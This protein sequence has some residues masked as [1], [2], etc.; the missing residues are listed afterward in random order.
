MTN[1][2][3]TGKAI[4]D[5]AKA[6]TEAGEMHAK[7]I[8]TMAAEDAYLDRGDIGNPVSADQLAWRWETPSEHVSRDMREGRFPVMSER[9]RVAVSPAVKTRIPHDMP[10]SEVATWLLDQ[11]SRDYRQHEIDALRMAGSI[12]AAL[13]PATAQ[14]SE[15]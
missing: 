7:Q 12:L 1:K 5:L 13:D 14:K 2:T 11:A 6:D 4:S 15:A 10:I 3:V 9:Q 8:A